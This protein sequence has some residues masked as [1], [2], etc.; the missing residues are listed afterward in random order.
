MATGA[1]DWGARTGSETEVSTV[2]AC[3]T[4][5]SGNAAWS[6]TSGGRGGQ[7][8]QPASTAAGCSSIGQQEPCTALAAWATK[9]RSNTA[10]TARRDTVD[11]LIS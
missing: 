3:T 5:H 2:A 9:A 11:F 6:V 7:C 4:Q 10:V 1:A 8:S